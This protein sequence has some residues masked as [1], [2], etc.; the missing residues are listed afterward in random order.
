MREA[1]ERA[2]LSQ[3]CRRRPRQEASASVAG[4]CVDI[5]YLRFGIAGPATGTSIEWA[6]GIADKRR[7]RVPRRIDDIALP[8]GGVA[9]GDAD[10]RA[11]TPGIATVDLEGAP[12][13]GCANERA[14]M[15]C[16]AITDLEKAPRTR[17]ASVRADRLRAYRGRCGREAPTS[18]STFAI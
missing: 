16:I 13:S 6:M 17:G 8:G 18:A 1:N 12:R 2:D 14:G 10:N 3:D 11:D 5:V 4:E 15:L 9:D 7:W